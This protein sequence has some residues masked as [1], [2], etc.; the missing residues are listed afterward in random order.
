MAGKRKQRRHSAQFKARVVREA[1][2]ERLTGSQLATKFGIHAG[3]ISQWKKEAVDQLHELFSATKK[4]QEKADEEQTTRLYEQIGKLQ[5]ELDWLK[6]KCGD[7][8]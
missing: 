3:Q 6:K 5:V 8:P 7:V 1:L 4:R 2:R